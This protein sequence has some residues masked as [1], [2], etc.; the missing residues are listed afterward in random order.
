MKDKGMIGFKRGPGCSVMEV[1][2][3]VHEFFM[4]KGSFFA[5]VVG[6]ESHPRYKDI[7]A[8]LEEIARRLR[9][10]GYV[11]NTN[12]VLFDIDEEE[13]GAALWRHSEKAA[14]AFGLISLDEDLPIRIVKNHRICGDS[15]DVTKIISKL[16]NRE[17]IIRDRNR[18]HH[19]KDG[20]CSCKDYW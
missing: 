20:E 16:Y 11:A 12:P 14:I 10:S 7:K 1:D 13:K 19:F 9:L 2:G 5:K 3:E 4:G 18:F 17:I 8:M 6:R 15:H